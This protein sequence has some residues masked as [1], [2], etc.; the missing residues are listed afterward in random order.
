MPIRTFQPG[1]EIA[2]A[3]I[4]NLAA[5]PLPA[6][7]P[8]TAE[9]ISRRHASAVADTGARFYAVEDGEIVGYA[10]FSPNGRISYPWC[11]PGAERVR[12]PLLEAILAAMKERK[13][14]EAWAAYR[15]DWTPVLEFLHE[16]GFLDKRQMINYL[17]EVSE[18][19]PDTILPPDR[20]IEPL[21]RDEIRDLHAFAQGID[22]HEDPRDF[23]RFYTQ[24]PFYDF[25]GQLVA[26]KEART[27]KMLGVALLVIADR[28]ADPTQINAAMPCFRFGTFGTERERHK[29]VNGLFSAAFADPIDGELLLG[30]L[31]RTQARPAGLTHITAQAP[32]DAPAVCALYDRF[33]QRQ[34]AFPILSRR[35]Q[36]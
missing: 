1:D 2:Q 14:P 30:W 32:S 21:G 25:S 6:F 22:P 34:G 18:L 31:V 27:R 9:E 23:E 5:G 20:V 8:A 24:N 7:K 28:F 35:L 12:E 36:D 13:I 29:R 3:R 10:S 16:Q 15:A 4:Y 19:L 11:L 17:A 26:L 33:L